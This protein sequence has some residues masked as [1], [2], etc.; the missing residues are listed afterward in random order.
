[1][2]TPAEPG[3]FT[4][5]W[6]AS[7]LREPPSSAGFSRPSARLVH[8]EATRFVKSA[9]VDVAAF[10]FKANSSTYGLRLVCNRRCH[11]PPKGPR[12]RAVKRETK[13]SSEHDEDPGASSSL[14]AQV[15]VCVFAGC[16]F[17]FPCTASRSDPPRRHLK[18][19]SV[20]GIG[21]AHG[22]QSQH[23]CVV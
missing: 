9:D 4:G 20:A 22:I 13:D 14:S 17:T 3:S 18:I 11:M 2:Q 8:S 19:E 5:P 6:L 7:G 10:C 1:M 12:L 15:L 16:T 23:I 21:A